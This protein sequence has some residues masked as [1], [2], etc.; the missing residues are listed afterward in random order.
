VYVPYAPLPH[1]AADADVPNQNGSSAPPAA[2]AP[3]RNRAEELADRARRLMARTQQLQARL[4]QNG[5]APRPLGPVHIVE[6]KSNSAAT[7]SNVRHLYGVRET[8]RGVLFVHPGSPRSEVCIAGDFNSWTPQRTRLR[9][10]PDLGIHEACVQIPPG[11]HEYRLVVD[12]RWI[13]DP[14]N[15]RGVTNP[16]GERNSLVVVTRSSQ[17]LSAGEAAD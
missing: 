6:D 1:H 9:Y 10:N 12:G 13:A 16:Y 2:D 3:P 15:E 7:A 5:N 4:E 17:E 14:F 11:A 8:S